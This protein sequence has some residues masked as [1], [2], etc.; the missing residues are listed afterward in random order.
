MH[1]QVESFGTAQLHL[2]L[3][4]FQHHISNSAI[5]P[6]EWSFNIDEQTVKLGCGT[7]E[8]FH[9]LMPDKISDTDGDLGQFTPDQAVFVINNG[10][11]I[12]SK[13]ASARQAVC[14]AY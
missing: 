7:N 5:T 3:V 11:Y 13:R 14:S 8:P 2:I 9:F 6:Q 10:P 1:L 4:L 12:S